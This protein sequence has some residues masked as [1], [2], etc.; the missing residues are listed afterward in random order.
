M[1]EELV[2]RKVGERAGLGGEE[3]KALLQSIRSSDL[4][5]EAQKLVALL[6]VAGEALGRAPEGARGVLAPLVAS[7]LAPAL[8]PDSKLERIAEAAA[9]LKAVLGDESSRRAVEEVKLAVDALVRRL[10]E[11]EK[12]REEEERARLAKALDDLTALVAQL[13]E[14]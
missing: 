14:R 4:A 7:V 11:L 2:L 6:G 3:V 5:E 12:V 10:E 9:M 8:N 1:V 13:Q